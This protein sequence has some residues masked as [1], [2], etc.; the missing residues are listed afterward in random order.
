M[1]GVWM[2]SN[3]EII[4]DNPWSFFYAL[5]NINHFIGVIQF[6]F[7]LIIVE[8]CHIGRASYIFTFYPSVLVSFLIYFF[9][10]QIILK[11]EYVWIK[12]WSILAY[13]LLHSNV[14]HSSA[15]AQNNAVQ[16]V[17]ETNIQKYFKAWRTWKT[18][19][20]IVHRRIWFIAYIET[21]FYSFVAFNIFFR[22]MFNI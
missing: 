6:F 22:W 10:I 3:M 12:L 15:T 4:D 13:K 18:Q 2:S 20:S 5:L 17:V 9:I 16:S 8:S 1:Q 14:V 21:L 7:N 19:F 11:V